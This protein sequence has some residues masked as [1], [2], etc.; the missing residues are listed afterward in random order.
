MKKIIV[1][2]LVLAMIFGNVGFALVERPKKPEMTRLGEYY[3]TDKNGNA[4]YFTLNKYFLDGQMVFC[5]N[6]GKAVDERYNHFDTFDAIPKETQEKLELA[7]ALGWYASEKKDDDYIKTQLAI[8]SLLNFYKDLDGKIEKPGSNRKWVVE[9]LK[10]LHETVLERYEQLRYYSA[11]RGKTLELNVGEKKEFHDES[12]VLEKYIFYKKPELV[13]AEI[14]SNN[15][16]LEGVKEGTE[17]AILV[18]VEGVPL[19]PTTYWIGAPNRQEMIQTGLSKDLQLNFTIKVN[20]KPQGSVVI[21]K[22]DAKGTPLAGVTFSLLSKDGNEVSKTT[23]NEMGEATF[24]GV[25]YDTYFVKETKALPG[26]VTDG[27]QHEVVIGNEEPVVIEVKND[28]IQV[29][30][31][32]ID[33]ITKA[34]VPGFEISL[35]PVGGTTGPKLKTEEKEIIL[36]EI[37]KGTY[38]ITPLTSP[39]GYALPKA[40]EILVKD[41]A[42]V[43]K[44]QLVAQKNATT[45][46]LQKI[47]EVTKKALQGV[48]FTILDEK[49]KEVLRSKTD[50]QGKIEATLLEGEYTIKEDEA[51]PG[52]VRED[53][54]KVTVKEDQTLTITNQ[55]T[56][57]KIHCV[58]ETDAPLENVKIDVTDEKGKLLESVTS[59]KDGVTLRGLPVGVVKLHVKSAPEP[60]NTEAVKDFEVKEVKAEQVVTI[61][62]QKNSGELLVRTLDPKGKALEGASYE[63]KND[64]ETLVKKDEVSSL[65][66]TL[67]YGPYKVLQTK[68]VSGFVATQTEQT[69]EVKKEQ[70]VVTFTM[71]PTKLSMKIVDEKMNPIVGANLKLFTEKGN[72]VDSWSSKDSARTIERLVPG[73]YKLQAVSVPENFEKPKEMVFELQETSKLQ[74]VVLKAQG[75]ADNVILKKTDELGNALKD[76][77][78]EILTMDG[79]TYKEA[80]TDDQGKI[81]FSIPKGDYFIRETEAPKGFVK[82][83]AKRYFRIDSEKVMDF[84]YVNNATK[85]GFRVFDEATKEPVKDVTLKLTDE[86]GVV[87]KTFTPKD[88]DVFRALPVGKYTIS[89]EKAPAGYARLESQAIEI[90][91]A[92]GTQ[93]FDIFLRRAGGTITVLVIDADS[94]KPIANSKIEIGGETKVELITDNTGSASV[95]LNEGD[96]T[97]EQKE[98]AENYELNPQ[99][100]EVKVDREHRVN[101]VTIENALK[102]EVLADKETKVT[103]KEKPTLP[104]TGFNYSMNPAIV[105]LLAGAG[106]LLI[107]KRMR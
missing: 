1:C 60:Y 83:A 87:V 22:T 70:T 68:G 2:M 3:Y 38:T 101:H 28:P 34:P 102:K 89:V 64:K 10:E 79:K 88:G 54:Q 53:D 4:T 17:E 84:T 41:Q 66:A 48:G 11:I 94:K 67:P 36:S 31:E 62:F 29:A 86:K 104:K 73:T 71:L 49:G 77:H 97:V 19:V 82:D 75:R 30:F 42:G 50:E 105:F 95:D 45:F 69:A 107:A 12:G 72:L 43:Q 15:L 98:T 35:L 93:Y 8:W 92:T 55:K 33:E 61:R 18:P 13:V 23:T 103:K 78:F 5:L 24:S 63:I 81:S 27:T 91:E 58:N 32:V 106:I 14:T 99:K 44:F 56:N 7:V 21:K 85:T 39:Q 37:P 20:A 40:E 6:P 59:V 16:F 74:E 57:V 65:L 46:I 96:F 51:L 47:D 25:A 80:V 26:F 52:Y 9:G 76:A 90:R 100:F